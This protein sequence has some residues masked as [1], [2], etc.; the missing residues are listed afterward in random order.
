MQSYQEKP[1]ALHGVI[2]E[3]PAKTTQPIE[4]GNNNNSESN[5]N[6]NSNEKT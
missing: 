3:M 5:E 6:R 2:T 4:S 1:G